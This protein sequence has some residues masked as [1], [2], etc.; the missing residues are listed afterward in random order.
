MDQYSG[1]H[2]D[3]ELASRDDF[4]L[5][6]AAISLKKGGNPIFVPTNPHGP[7]SEFKNIDFSVRN[8]HFGPIKNSLEREFL[9][10]PNLGTYLLS[11]AVTSELTPI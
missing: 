7:P 3:P 10:T 9:W 6:A 8:G 4:W 5:T 2:L 1:F 11:M